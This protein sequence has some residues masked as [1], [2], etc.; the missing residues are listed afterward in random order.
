MHCGQHIIDLGLNTVADLVG[1]GELSH[2]C[3]MNFEKKMFFSE[4][5]LL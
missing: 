3:H 1:E 5:D 4:G 2:D